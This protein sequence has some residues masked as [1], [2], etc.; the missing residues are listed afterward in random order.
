MVKVVTEAN[1]PFID[2]YECKHTAVITE[3]EKIK[4]GELASL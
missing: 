2:E 1:K 3:I 4:A